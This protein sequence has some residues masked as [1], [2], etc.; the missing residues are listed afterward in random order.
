MSSICW[1]VIDWASL[2]RSTPRRGSTEEGPKVCFVVPFSHFNKNLFCDISTRMGNC[3]PRINFQCLL[4]SLQCGV[5]SQEIQF[6]R[7]R[8]R[9]HLRIKEYCIPVI[10]VLL[11][12]LQPVQYSISSCCSLFAIIITQDAIQMANIKLHVTY[13]K[14]IWM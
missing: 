12:V 11:F 3:Q 13:H 7:L 8:R 14:E 4:Y 9:L 1:N 10:W 6:K 2:F 5:C